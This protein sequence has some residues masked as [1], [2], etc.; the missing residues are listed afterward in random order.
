MNDTKTPSTTA[1]QLE[2]STKALVAVAKAVAALAD[3]V[4]ALAML[5]TTSAGVG[6]ATSRAVG[7]LCSSSLADM[8][9]PTE[10]RLRAQATGLAAAASTIGDQIVVQL[11]M[12]ARMAD[13]PV[14]E[15]A[16][17]AALVLK[18]SRDIVESA[19]QPHAEISKENLQ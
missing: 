5:T 16:A 7:I 10:K 12:M 8:T 13:V 14:E 6:L 2:A 3:R 19:T 18:A 15:V 1:E 11:G 4:E 17:D 9:A